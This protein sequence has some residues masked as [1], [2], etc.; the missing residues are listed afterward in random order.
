MS[1]TDRA[2]Q[3]SLILYA[4]WMTALVV[5][6]F[7]VA[8][9]IREVLLVLYASLLFAIG[10]SPIVRLIER[11][12]LLP[13]GSRRFPRWLAILVLYVFIIS[14]AAA[15]I[16]MILPPLTDQAREFWAH[17][18]QLFERVQTFLVERGL[19]QRPI[20]LEQAVAQA[21][22]SGDTVGTVFGAVRGVI[23]GLFGL[24]TILIVTFYLLVDSW[25]IHQTFL[26]FFPDHHRARV[27]A[28]TRDIT[29]KVSAWLAGQL[30]L[31]III[32]ST[33]AIGLWLLGV[34][35]FYVLAL[36]SAI[37]ELIPIV[38]PILAA[39][40]AVLVAGTV[41]YQKALAVIV[42]FVI[43]QQVENHVLVPKVM[44]RQVGVSAIIVIVSVLIGG[45]LLGVAGVLLAVPSA[46]ILQVLVMEVLAMREGGAKARTGS[47]SRG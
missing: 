24:V 28:A 26:R 19:M 21:P 18:D 10:F 44:E 17:K 12:H 9:Q 11:Q 38:G 33:S 27:D 31:G 15:V 42:F 8:Y 6:G 41:S 45:K 20:T 16:S 35:F 5:I 37:G 36:I 23:G 39:I 47:S 34:P 25:S 46:A 32:G 40:P 4:I 2:S 14:A 1:A 29:M 22:V 13:V 43:Q 30:F 7:W 3:K